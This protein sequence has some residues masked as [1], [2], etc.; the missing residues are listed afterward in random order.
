[1]SEKRKVEEAVNVGRHQR[2]CSICAHLEG[3]EIEHAFVGWRSPAVI[4]Q[5]YG[6][7]DRAGVYR[8]AHALGLFQKR[9]K[10]VRRL[11]NAL[12]KRLAK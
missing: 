12:S 9:Q 11:W 7:A 10:N 2:A 4:A 5:E 3:D 8:H 6:L 1:M